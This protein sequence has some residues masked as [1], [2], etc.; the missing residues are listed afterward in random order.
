MDVKVDIRDKEGLALA[1]APR[2]EPVAQTTVY[3]GTLAQ[4]E[5]RIHRIIAGESLPAL[6]SLDKLPIAQ[7]Q[8]QASEP[9]AAEPAEPAQGK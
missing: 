8:A 3:D 6:S 9:A 5:D 7:T 4:A 2:T 1:N